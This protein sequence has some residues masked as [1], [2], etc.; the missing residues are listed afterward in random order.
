MM[1]VRDVMTTAVICVNPGA[2]LKDVAQLLIDSRISGLPVVTDDGAVVGV[3][4]EADL[5]LKEGGVGAIHHR[6]LAR[7]LGDNAEAREAQAKLAATT[8]GEAMS[9]PAVTIGSGRPIREAAAL[10]TERGVNRL[11]V[12][13]DEH[14][15]GIVTRA[16]LVRA[17]LRSD[18]ELARAIRNDVIL[19][20]LW[21]DPSQFTVDVT[22]GVASISGRVERR[23]TAEMI[24]ETVSFVPG[25]IGVRASVQ[26]SVDDRDV[27]APGPDYLSP[28]S[29]H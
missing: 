4:S 16:D 20:I 13:D 23:S 6:R 25:L 22:D 5:I 1:T 19:K 21:L 28:F 2:P 24:E 15:V 27:E 14:L 29:I 9:S 10:M 17:Y 18:E 8:A 7:I 12:V 3:V 11:P 26:W